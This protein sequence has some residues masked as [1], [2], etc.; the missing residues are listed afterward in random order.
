MADAF[1]MV[2]LTPT[3]FLLRPTACSYM[4]QGG[5][6]NQGGY[7]NQPGFQGGYM[8]ANTTAGGYVNPGFVQT[9]PAGQVSLARCKR[10]GG[11]QEGGRVAV[12]W[13]GGV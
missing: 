2:G 8:D 4:D 12:R 9:T 13:G 10:E 7:V 1:C 6:I 3:F 5:Y 11:V